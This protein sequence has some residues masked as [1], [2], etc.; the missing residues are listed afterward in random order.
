MFL[1]ALQSFIVLNM[2][3]REMNDEAEVI[4]YW[5]SVVTPIFYC[6]LQSFHM[7]RAM[8][9]RKKKI[10]YAI[11]KAGVEGSLN[12]KN[13]K[14]VT[15][16]GYTPSLN[17][18]ESLAVCG[19]VGAQAS[20][21]ASL[22]TEEGWSGLRQRMKRRFTVGHQESVYSISERLQSSS[23]VGRERK[24]SS[25]TTQEEVEQGEMAQGV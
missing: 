3:R 10:S 9:D 18:E 12:V 23:D 17:R 25:G 14:L 11:K 8:T 16:A 15:K 5:C 4:D 2:S 7:L 6:L 24:S 22:N 20:S 1:M 19:F 21:A 13:L